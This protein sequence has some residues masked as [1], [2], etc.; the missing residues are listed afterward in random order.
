MGRIKK[1]GFCLSL[2]D[3][4][5]ERINELAEIYGVS[6]SEVVRRAVDEFYFMTMERL[7]GINRREK[8]SVGKLL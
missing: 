8:I 7:S 6:P 5:W 2:G 3:V 4:H 1:R